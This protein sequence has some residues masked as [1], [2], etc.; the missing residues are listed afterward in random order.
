MN[1]EQLIEKLIQDYLQRLGEGQYKTLATDF[2]PSALIVVSRERDG[3]W[4]NSYQSATEWLDGLKKNPIPIFQEPMFNVQVTI[5]SNRIAYLRAGFQVIRNHNVQSQGTEV[6]T[7]VREPSGW[8]IA[9]VTYTSQPV[10]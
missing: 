8:K 1:E 9:A 3:Q 5:D 7:L 6:F 2:A 10:R 4:T